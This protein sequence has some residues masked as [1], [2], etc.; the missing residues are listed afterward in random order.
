MV[1]GNH[2]EASRRVVGCNQLFEQFVGVGIPFGEA[3]RNAVDQQR[4]RQAGRSACRIEDDDRR[5][6]SPG[7]SVPA[8][9]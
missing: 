8:T 2:G 9:N 6:L 4:M 1:A 7:S 5:I 3:D